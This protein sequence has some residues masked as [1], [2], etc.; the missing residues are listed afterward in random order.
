VILVRNVM[1]TSEKE[2]RSENHGEGTDTINH[3][4]PDIFRALEL[5]PRAQPRHFGIRLDAVSAGLSIFGNNRS[6][7]L[8]SQRRWHGGVGGAPGP[9]LPGWPVEKCPLSAPQHPSRLP[10]TPPPPPCHRSKVPMIWFGRRLIAVR[11]RLFVAAHGLSVQ[12]EFFIA[13]AETLHQ[14]R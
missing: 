7:R 5:K 1:E 8:K 4:T 11:L 2:K 3:R 14:C 6:P 10:H 9:A 13:P 12:L